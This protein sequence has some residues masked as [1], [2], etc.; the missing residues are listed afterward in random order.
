MNSVEGAHIRA[1]GAHWV[2]SD[3][4]PWVSRK[5]LGYVSGRGAG[6]VEFWLPHLVCK[7]REE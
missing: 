5:R 1:L 2:H 7:G 6:E 4:T 3:L